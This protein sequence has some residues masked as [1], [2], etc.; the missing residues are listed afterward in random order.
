MA[1]FYIP[2]ATG[3]YSTRLAGSGGGYLRI[4]ID[5][6]YNSASNTSSLKTSVEMRAA[7]YSGLY[8]LRDG[9]SFTF[10]SSG[11]GAVTIDHHYHVRMSDSW[12]GIYYEGEGTK[13]WTST[14]AHAADGTCSIYGGITAAV[15][16]HNASN[17]WQWSGKSGTL[18]LSN[19]PSYTLTLNLGAHTGAAVKRNGTALSNGATIYRGDTLVF[20]YSP[21]AGYSIGTHTVN[22][23][24]RSNGY[25]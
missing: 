14:V 20:S 11:S 24:T 19:T 12:S 5:Q 23:T 17:I 16:Q 18:S 9:G 13:Y 6:T 2:D 22:G 21:D 3:W 15:K 8:D 25:S 10:P 1:T 4:R 7:A